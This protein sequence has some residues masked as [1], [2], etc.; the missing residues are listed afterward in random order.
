VNYIRVDRVCDLIAGWSV[1]ARLTPAISIGRRLGVRNY[2]SSRATKVS[3]SIAVVPRSRGNWRAEREFR[4]RARFARNNIFIREA[5]VEEDRGRGG[6]GIQQGRHE[7]LSRLIYIFLLRIF[8]DRMT[9]DRIEAAGNLVASGKAGK[10]SESETG[11][12]KPDGRYPPSSWR[13]PGNRG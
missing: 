4:K 9:R 10:G 3:L 7:Y 5:D 6:C 13:S 11:V 2:D 8:T 12:A 1:R